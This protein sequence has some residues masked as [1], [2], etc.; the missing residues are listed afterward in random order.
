MFE[1]IL[2]F[3]PTSFNFCPF[4]PANTRVVFGVCDQ[5]GW[6]VHL[7]ILLTVTR[8]RFDLERADYAALAM[9]VYISL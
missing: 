8:N 7:L 3:A 2:L 4:N 5:Y 6:G 9:L 1:H